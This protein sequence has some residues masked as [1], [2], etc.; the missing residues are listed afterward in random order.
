MIVLIILCCVG[1]KN[2]LFPTLSRSYLQN[3]STYIA[4]NVHFFSTR[5]TGLCVDVI[6]S[7]VV[8][9]AQISP[10]CGRMPLPGLSLWPGRQPYRYRT[11]VDGRRGGGQ[12]AVAPRSRNPPTGRRRDSPISSSLFSHGPPLCAVG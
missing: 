9:F 2:D 3:R 6:S 4:E 12:S 7:S 10:T 8:S 1:A 5:G 11:I